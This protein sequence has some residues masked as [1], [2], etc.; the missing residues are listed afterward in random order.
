MMLMVREASWWAW[1]V[2]AVLL[3]VHLT[4]WGPALPLAIGLS[5]VQVL[6]FRWRDGS[7]G[8]FHVQ[9][10]VAYTALLLVCTWPPAKPLIWLPA[11]GTAAQVVFGYCLL[12]RCLSLAA[13]NRRE[14]LSV[15][16]VLRTFFSR[17]IAGNVLQGLPHVRT[18]MIDA[19][20]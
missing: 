16:L 5:A 13:W 11:I 9:V 18:P 14:P 6:A 3:V 8:A 15:D 17:P 2:T 7:F 19:S 12:A 1:A 20:R 4:G 10:R